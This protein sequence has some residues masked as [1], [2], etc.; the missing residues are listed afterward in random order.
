MRVNTR[1]A[2]GLPIMSMDAQQISLTYSLADQSFERT[3]SLGILNLSTGLL[4][5]LARRPEIKNLV[6]LTNPDLDARLSPISGVTTRSIRGAIAGRIRRML[7]DQWRVYSAARNARTDWLLLPKG[8][9]PF[10]RPCPLRLATYVHDAVHDFYATNYPGV[11]PPLEALYFSKCLAATVRY[12]KV[13]FTNSEFTRSELSRFAEKRHLPLP[14]IIHAG[15]GFGH[16]PSNQEQKREHLVVLVTPWPHKRAALAVEYLGQWH[17]QTQFMGKIYWIG[18]LPE[19]LKLPD[20]PAWEILGRT[21]EPE[22]ERIVGQARALVY[23]SEYE[24]FGMPPVEAVL[25]GT[26]P[27]YSDIPATREVMQ[28]GGCPFSNDSY[29][30]FAAA[31]N[32]GLAVSPEELSALGSRFLGRHNWE[33]V[34]QRVTQA[35]LLFR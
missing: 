15:I 14:P 8:Y 2:D 27:I 13:I 29:E 4:E 24:G 17:R 9:A 34:A 6:A 3:K 18:T 7:W 28:G 16:R 10:V 11:L 35:L 33:A 25:S 31:L 1:F 32:K 12:S 5:A 23:F 30:S 26:C 19:K 20:I 22:Y 21:E